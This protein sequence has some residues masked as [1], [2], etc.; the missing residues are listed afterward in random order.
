MRVVF[1]IFVTLFVITG[2]SRSDVFGSLDP[3]EPILVC[4]LTVTGDQLLSLSVG[5]GSVGDPLSTAPPYIVNMVVDTGA[6]HSLIFDPRI[7]AQKQSTY[8]IS[9]DG[10][11]IKFQNFVVEKRGVN[12]VSLM[13]N[14]CNFPVAIPQS[15]VEMAAPMKPDLGEPIQGLVGLNID[16]ISE[17]NLFITRPFGD[18]LKSISI[19]IPTV[20][21]PGVRNEGVLVVKRKGSGSIRG[22]YN[23]PYMHVNSRHYWSTI[24]TKLKVGERTV[25]TAPDGKLI[26]VVFDTGSNYF[27]VSEGLLADVQEAIRDGKVGFVIETMAYLDPNTDSKPMPVSMRF[28]SDSFGSFTKD[29]SQG[30]VVEKVDQSQFDDLAQSEIVV[31]GTRGLRGKTLSIFTNDSPAKIGEFA[32]SVKN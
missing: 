16:A 13:T 17:K 3:P 1:S 11:E 22:E 29:L 15:S 2:A 32:L 25:I 4:S 14:A 6:K 20:L 8:S 7:P 12:T 30:F 23:G 27:G 31:I 5:G 9:P 21:Q 19:K 26:S 24:V 28:P 18:D 10:N